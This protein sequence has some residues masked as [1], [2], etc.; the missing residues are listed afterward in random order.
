[1]SLRLLKVDWVLSDDV[2]VTA[3]PEGAC[4][5]VR[6]GSH[7]KWAA[8][9]FFSQRAVVRGSWSSVYRRR[10]DAK[11]AMSMSK[12]RGPMW[13]AAMRDE[14]ELGW[15]GFAFEDFQRCR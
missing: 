1:M 8:R 4:R 14:M 9:I 3:Q 7:N 15:A 2:V 5:A 11:S 12:G 13:R 6:E 10:G